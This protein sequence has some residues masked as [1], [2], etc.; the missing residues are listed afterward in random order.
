M[1]NTEKIN[2][3]KNHIKAQCDFFGKIPSEQ[4]PNVENRV[5]DFKNEKILK[6]KSELKDLNDKIKKL[7]NEQ[8]CINCAIFE[9]LEE[10]ENLKKTN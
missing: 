10:L 2:W 1:E 9:I 5:E 6:F 4:I 8:D 3:Y 7:K